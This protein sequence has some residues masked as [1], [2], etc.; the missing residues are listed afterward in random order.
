MLRYPKTTILLA[1]FALFFTCGTG[2]SQDHWINGFGGFF[3][4]GSN[5]AD[6]T[7]A[8]PTDD[9]IY[10]L[11]ATYSVDFDEFT[12]NITNV[13]ADVRF[14]EV[15]FNNA[16]LNPN[17]ELGYSVGS[18]TVVNNSTAIFSSN[19]NSNVFNLNVEDGLIIF[20]GR[21]EI[22][23]GTATCGLID[24][25]LTGS[26]TAIVDGPETQLVMSEDPIWVGRGV[27]GGLFVQNGA[28]VVDP[29]T[30]RIG[31]ESGGIGTVVM[32]G[33]NSTFNA[34]NLAVGDVDNTLGTIQLFDNSTLSVDSFLRMAHFDGVLG[35]GSGNFIRAFDNASIS[36]GMDLLMGTVGD[37]EILLSDMTQLTVDGDIFIGENGAIL[38][39]GFDPP[40]LQAQQIQNNGL[41][42]FDET[43]TDIFGTV[44][45]DGQIESL[46]SSFNIFFG[47]LQNPG[48][49]ETQQNAETRIIGTASGEGLFTGLGT[50]SFHGDVQPG[51]GSGVN[52]TG[53]LNVVGDAVL[54]QQLIIEFSADDRDQFWVDNNLTINSGCE[55]SVTTLGGFVPEIGESY[56]IVCSWGTTTGTFAGLPEGTKVTNIAG[57][58]LNISYAGGAD[59]IDIVLNGAPGTSIK[60]DVNGDGMV[61]LL[62]VDPFVAVTASSVYQTE[63]D[64][65]CD[66]N[67]D[68]LD[69]DSFVSLLTG[70]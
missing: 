56:L 1:H 6:G 29:F 17:I 53:I 2:F 48:F 58:D 12:G 23:D 10:D 25:G 37:A 67:V 68:L 45:N 62:D 60:G 34:G 63:A 13:S 3:D 11:A 18:F 49:V 30:T 36:V 65:N 69:V 46:N 31:A 40:T 57:V 64:T 16:S 8:G 70:G 55:L 47:D 51:A 32:T 27:N 7:A 26:S 52:D 20:D 42:S 33:V 61:T 43:G 66:G 38:G 50:V 14:G 24:V 21:F 15:S 44:V 19:L 22:Y 9:A 54:D 5:W 39:T 35:A 41:L 59:G 28:S 4:V